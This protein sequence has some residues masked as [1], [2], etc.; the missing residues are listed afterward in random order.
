[1]RLW[2]S[3][4]SAGGNSILRGRFSEW[5]MRKR[6]FVC[7]VS[8]AVALIALSGHIIYRSTAAY[9]VPLLERN[10]LLQ[11]KAQ[12]VALKTR[13]QSA[14][15]DLA[16]LAAAGE[17]DETALR[18]FL[19]RESLVNDQLYAELAYQS[20]DGQKRLA[21]IAAGGD[22]GTVAPELLEGGHGLLGDLGADFKRAFPSEP[23]TAF[24]YP[25]V[26]TAGGERS[27]RGFALRL[28]SPV[29]GASGHLRGRLT[30]S[31]NLAVLRDILSE[32]SS[33]RSPLHIFPHNME[34][35]SGY[36]FDPRGWMLFQSE[37]E[38]PADSTA[39]LLAT[40]NA[41]SGL[42][43]DYGRA[44]FSVAFRPFASNE[45]YWRMVMQVGKNVDGIMNQESS[46]LSWRNKSEGIVGY[47]PVS[48]NI[49]P[50]QPPYVLGG[51]AYSSSIFYSTRNSY[52]QYAVI[53]VTM[54]CA[55][56]ILGAFSLL[57]E[58]VTDA[59][60]KNMSG[61]LR[62]M[63][64]NNAWTP[65]ELDR[66]SPEITTLGNA[67]NRLIFALEQKKVA[68]LKARQALQENLNRQ[69]AREER[70]LDQAGFRPAEDSDDSRL[71]L[72]GTGPAM[73][74][75]RALIRKAGPLSADVLI[76]GETGTGKELAAEAIHKAGP[77]ASKPFI[78]I[79]CGALDE[80][81]LLDALFG[82]V[83]GAFS[84]A[85]TDRKGAFI[86]ADG[87][88][89]FLD[90][91]GNASLKV[92]QAL[93]RALSVRR[94]SPLGSD[95]EQPFDVRIVAATNLDLRESARNGTFREDLYYRLAVITINTPPL[96]EHMED[97]PMLARTFLKLSAA[98]LGRS[99]VTLT[100]G[101]LERLMQHDWPGN[102][103]EL[104][105]TLTRTLAFVDGFSLFAEDLRFG[106]G[107][108]EASRLENKQAA[109]SQKSWDNFEAGSY[110]AAPGAE[111]FC[112]PPDD[113][114]PATPERLEQSPVAPEADLES[115]SPRQKSLWP[116]I[117]R[118]GGITRA[119]YQKLLP[120][121]VPVR[122][123]QYDLGDFVRRGMLKKEGGGPST[124]YVVNTSARA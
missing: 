92:Q 69:P 115:L 66:A 104:K 49:A 6:L 88:T 103:R 60:L 98:H 63:E 102:V 76:C 90:E 91:I 109:F 123:A 42:E 113:S 121:G 96:R 81:L 45:A 100:H 32:Y 54:L 89:L 33:A 83:R 50:D 74:E 122:T 25:V 28:C 30:L 4:V 5:S 114:R 36:F 124:R 99:E 70:A 117:L 78:C 13:I 47:A 118:Q 18:R 67:V 40:D 34:L 97:L 1:M 37:G 119:G 51:V 72:L 101:A 21:L 3:L 61:Q 26:H 53:G 7:F 52:Q 106:G 77:R 9:V 75:L 59:P 110:T 111:S 82:H 23:F 55:F 62:D 84:D 44:G 105:H 64:I 19:E 87:G 24:S 11:A 35:Q 22:F 20:V 39:P 94:V 95:A 48:V 16:R 107:V 2:S 17:P 8:G 57:T 116:E 108:I 58:A 38:T 112:R 43:G 71:G 86:A 12:A 120:K 15:D 85:R 41:R 31:L 73:Q 29:Y 14:R 93:L 46:L 68:L 56:V 27:A 79:N 10:I 80:N 65:L